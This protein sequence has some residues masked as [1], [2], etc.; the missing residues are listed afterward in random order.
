MTTQAPKFTNFYNLKVGTEYL[1]KKKHTDEYIN[2]GILLEYKDMS[3]I[4]KVCF[5]DGPTY[6]Y[7]A[8]K[9]NFDGELFKQFAKQ[10]M[11][12]KHEEFYEIYDGFCEKTK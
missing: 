7:R 10:F 6:N 4:Q 2:C 8:F 5:H 11:F 12:I 9:V 1:L 3:D